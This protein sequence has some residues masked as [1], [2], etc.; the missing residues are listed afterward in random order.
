MTYNIT[1]AFDIGSLLIMGN[2]ATDGLLATALMVVVFTILSGGL[3]KNDRSIGEAMTFGGVVTSMLGT[4]L[5]ALDHYSISPIGVHPIALIFFWII[6][7]V[8]A[9]MLMLRGE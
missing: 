4:F 8:G 5:F 9:L 7:G 1:S 3:I 6:T 2:S